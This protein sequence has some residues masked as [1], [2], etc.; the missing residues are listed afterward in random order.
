MSVDYLG[1]LIADAQ[2]ARGD[3]AQIAFM[4]PGGIRADLPSGE[5]TYGQ[6]FTVQPFGNSLVSMD[7]TGAQILRLLEQQW[8]PDRTRFLQ[9]SRGF[10]YTWDDH[11]PVGQRVVVA[12]LEDRPLEP[13]AT[14]R[15]VVNSFLASGGDNFGVL[16]EGT[17]VVGGPVDVDALVEYLGEQPQP[18][19]ATIEGRIAHLN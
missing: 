6:L 3:G 9:V 19:R 10:R 15:V 1:N 7:L 17:N 11:R 18:V 8:Q 13:A 4:N 2:R 12:S 5:L 14:Y 16:T